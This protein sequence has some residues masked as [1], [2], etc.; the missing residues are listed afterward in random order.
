[1]ERLQENR[2]YIKWFE[3]T[4]GSKKIRYWLAVV[5]VGIQNLFFA[6]CLS[7]VS[8]V[9]INMDF[10]IH[11]FGV[12]LAIFL[13]CTFVTIISS[14][15]GERKLINVVE[16][17]T[18]EKRKT[19]YE[20]ILK[21]S[22]NYFDS[23]HKSDLYVRIINDIEV[24]KG[25]YEEVLPM[26]FSL[27]MGIAG[28]ALIIIFWNKIL[29]FINLM[30]GIISFVVFNRIS[31][32]VRK[33][34][35]NLRLKQDEASAVVMDAI[36]GIKVIKNFA[37]ENRM[38]GKY[39]QITEDYREADNRII[40]K[41]AEYETLNAFI[42]LG[43]FG[44]MLFIGI[45]LVKLETARM[46]DVISSTI[47]STSVIWMYRSLGQHLSSFSKCLVSVNRIIEIEDSVSCEQMKDIYDKQQ[48]ISD[49]NT[50]S[51][52]ICIKNLH[53][54]LSNNQEVLKNISLSIQ[55][56][57]CVGIK[58]ESGAG[59]TTL[60]RT[61]MGLY[62]PRNGKMLCGGDMFSQ[63]TLQEWRKK[64]IYIS[65]DPYLFS[66]SILDNIRMNNTDVLPEQV[67]EA[68]KIVNAHEFIEK[69]PHKYETIMKESKTLSSGERQRVCLARAFINKEAILLLDEPTSALD[70]ETEH[71]FNEGLMKLRQDRIVIIV[72]HRDSIFKYCDYIIHMEGGRLV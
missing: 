15:V 30:V 64:F 61:L 50:I 26:M 41:T 46:S 53:V 69:L 58:G 6:Y 19:V 18:F 16:E 29:A 56:N 45:I 17:V 21:L 24:I 20:K 33:D 57:K 65:Q 28:S 60:L 67:V 12:V 52:G 55:A 63:V 44:A 72:S 51:E 66:G 14:Y 35:G 39:D 8:S 38:C 25:F 34:T 5:L 62:I 4:L 59:K 40:K 23:H 11:S 47:L 1:M 10:S 31:R 49:E 7:Q 48:G 3:T 54:E 42:M 70:L 43:V 71:K 22:L 37:L 9:L 13:L 2:V 32:I 68:A 36:K 27:V